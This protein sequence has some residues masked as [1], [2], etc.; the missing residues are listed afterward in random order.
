MLW[1]GGLGEAEQ[2]EVPARAVVASETQPRGSAPASLLNPTAETA[3]GW[4]ELG[5]L[6]QAA[7]ATMPS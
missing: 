3:P 4:H 6:A 1:R 7:T 5:T 2:L